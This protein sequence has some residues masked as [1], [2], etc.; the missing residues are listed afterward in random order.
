MTFNVNCKIKFDNCTGDGDGAPSSGDSGGGFFFISGSAW[1]QYGI[2][3]A[4]RTN[5]TGHAIPN[6]YHIYT[7]LTQFKSWMI[8]IVHQTGGE[9]GEAVFSITMNCYFG[10]VEL[11]EPDETLYK[12]WFYD[13]DIRG[14]NVETRRVDGSHLSGKTNLDVEVIQFQNGTMFYLPNGYGSFFENVRY[15]IVG[16]S[17]S[18]RPMLGTKTIRRSDLQNL[19]NLLEITFLRNEIETLNGDSLW[20]LASLQMFKLVDN[21]LAAFSDETFIKSKDLR[22]IYLNSNQISSLPVG[23]FANNL[24]LEI[25]D[26]RNNFLTTLDGKMFQTNA[27]LRGVSFVSNLLAVLPKNLFENKISLTLVDFK[28][29]SLTTLDEALFETNV[30][31]TA[32]SFSANRIESLPRKLFR[33]NPLLDIIDFRNNSLTTLHDHLFEYNGKLRTVSFASNRLELIQRNLFE[34]NLLLQWLDLLNNRIKVVDMKFD[35][36][37]HLRLIDLN[38]NTCVNAKYIRQNNRNTTI[39]R[40]IFRNI[41]EFQSH[42]SAHCYSGTK[43]FDVSQ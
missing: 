32:A 1:V 4:I 22:E 33:N 6:A 20:D 8:E 2:V 21:K 34:N 40:K 15:M 37:Q 42:I 5:A 29:N 27:R 17:N 39:D 41:G 36:Y 11:T 30:N 16:E 14:N 10:Y 25:V 3:S 23:L 31:L 18:D 24:L 35:E 26:F 43:L 12:C 9:V 7:N 38:L 19:E 13:I 28:N